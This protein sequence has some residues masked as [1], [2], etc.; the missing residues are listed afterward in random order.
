MHLNRNNHLIYDLKSSAGE[1]G[2]DLGAFIELMHRAN[3]YEASKTVVEVGEQL[4]CCSES[5]PPA[6]VL[7]IETAYC[8][9]F[10]LFYGR[11]LAADLIVFV[12]V[13]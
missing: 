13:V 6:L 10:D 2:L 5:Q 8:F 1:L 3:R 4:V 7:F 12:S 11:T 9:S